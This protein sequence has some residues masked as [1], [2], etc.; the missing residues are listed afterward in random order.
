MC[1][2][3]GE[4]I[5]CVC[6]CVCVCLSFGRFVCVCVCVCV[7]VSP[8]ACCV[9]DFGFFGDGCHEQCD[10][11]GGVPCDPQT[12][13]CL[14]KCPPGYYGEECEKGEEH[15]YTHTHT[16][17]HRKRERK[18]DTHRQT[19][20]TANMAIPYWETK[21]SQKSSEGWIVCAKTKTHIH[22]ERKG[23]RRSR[24]ERGESERVSEKKLGRAACR[25]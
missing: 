1:L 7:C 11:R 13:E 25:G 8:L 20:C 9:Y 6:V 5:V 18:R 23:E 15:T 17:T 21:H 3:Y 10:C 16:H 14:L 2:H 22:R 4:G 19:H 12:G 24:R